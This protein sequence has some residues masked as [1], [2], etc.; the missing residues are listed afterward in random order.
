M[1]P[2]NQPVL[3]S[4]R[5]LLRAFDLQ[6]AERVRQLAGDER[7]A[8]V[9]RNIPHPYPEGL[10]EEWIAGHATT[11]STGEGVSYAITLEENH[12]LIGC[13]SLVNI[14]DRQAETG[15]W[16]GVDFWGHG[17]A[18]EACKALVEFGFSQ[19]GLNR[20]FAKYLERNP[21][22]GRVLTKSGFVYAGAGIEACGYRQ[23]NEKYILCEI[24]HPG[25]RYSP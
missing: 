13:I 22:S 21:A 23:D 9:T 20:I 10:A 14:H 19:L 11:C 16:L 12:Q 8:D 1:I 25:G 17:Y 24:L 7:V 15:Y 5:L 2:A 6:D 18:T 3:Q 4:E